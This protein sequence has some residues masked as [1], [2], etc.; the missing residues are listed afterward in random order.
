MARGLN[1]LTTRGMAALKDDGAYADGGGLYLIVKGGS[2]T[3]QFWHKSNGKRAKSGLGPFPAI[4]LA[5]ARSKAAAL[6]AIV[7]RGESVRV[8][9]PD[10]GSTTFGT[11]ADDVLQKKMFRS[12]SHQRQWE[13]SLRELAKP[14]SHKPVS[15]ITRQDIIDV[16]A[17]HWHR[18]PE[19]AQKLRARIEKVLA[20]ATALDL[21]TGNNPAGWRD[22][23]KELLEPQDPTKRG[24]FNAMP[25]HQVP[26]LAERLLGLSGF[27]TRGLLFAILTAARSGEVRGADWGE[28]D[29]NAKIWVVPKERMKAKRE[30]V[31]P[32]SDQAIAILEALPHRSGLLFPNSNTNALSQ[33]ALSMALR[34][35]L[36]PKGVRAEKVK[37]NATVHGFRSSFR[38]WCSENGVARE[39]AELCLAHLI[40]NAVEQAYARS[41]VLNR[42]RDVMQSWADFV[43]QN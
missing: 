13:R 15:E 28:I 8:Q 21:R 33:M 11:I 6:R 12:A 3:W 38:D 16:L 40:G 32:L 17:P 31:V 14:L 27:S 24:H 4:T 7:A 36:A 10:R 39:V 1:L 35:A 29:L 23:L 30:H 9:T 19:T 22:G 5:D 18:V 2:R 20:R 26:P 42:R 25:Y 37:L 43:L 34:R 41:T